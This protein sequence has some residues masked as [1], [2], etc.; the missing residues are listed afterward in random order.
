MVKRVRVGLGLVLLAALPA[1]AAPNHAPSDP[2]ATAPPATAPV[3]DPF[4]DY[5]AIRPNVEFW[6][7]VFAEWSLTQI[8]VH[9]MD[10]PGVVYEV[11]DL[12]GPTEEPYTEEQQEFLEELTQRWQDRL[13]GLESKVANGQPL[14]D[15]EK[16]WA[17]ALGT[18]AGTDKITDAGERVRTQRGL[19]ERFRRGLEI[20]FRY[21]ALFRKIFREAGLPE[22]LAYLPHVES[23]FQASALSS[24]G[25]V[26]VWQFTRG[27]GRLFMSINSAIDERLDP[28]AAARGAAEYMQNA[29][30]RLQT[31]P[32]A[33]TAYNHGVRGMQRATR[34][35]G[36]DYERI[37]R[38]YTGRLFGFA[39]KNFYSEFLAARAIAR[40]PH[41]YFPEGYTP[42][43]P[44]MLDRFVL[45]QRTTPARI[46]RA[47]DVPLDALTPINPAW[48]HR[49]VSLG[50]SL[51]RGIEVWLP[52]GTLDRL[53][54]AGKTPMLSP[55]GWVDAEG[56]YVVQRGDT[57]SDVA[58][59][60]RM[61]V[62]ELRDL[63]G[64][65]AGQTLIREG[66][67][68]R[69]RGAEPGN[70]SHVVRRGDTLTRIAQVY[71]VRLSDLLRLNRLD[72]KSMIHPGQVIRIPP[73]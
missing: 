7:R 46:A 50:L 56:Y 69:V 14:T 30:D 43:P 39:S 52:Q 57:L 31:W 21:D 1:T 26:G 67:T 66:Q 44:L 13:R 59:A 34:A 8:T 47:Y 20:S 10:Y 11:V 16:E 4:P 23:S 45:D 40:D 65:A 19:R 49:A 22:D 9:D 32:L 28:V 35:L 62:V 5:E 15:P 12:P 61:S 54:A 58:L 2:T 18:N 73:R 72:M 51:P 70:T 71:R 27:T 3:V 17:I 33:L 68:L 48:S 38:E 25:A 60:H 64:M 6:K 55:A 37:Y 42:E 63:N 41:T 24:A 36:R 53:A 29:Y